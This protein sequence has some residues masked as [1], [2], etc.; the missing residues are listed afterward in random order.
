MVHILNSNLNKVLASRISDTVL[1]LRLP[2]SSL[3]RIDHGLVRFRHCSL[4]VDLEVIQATFGTLQRG[5]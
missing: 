1:P 4:G 5:I 2:Q 3:P